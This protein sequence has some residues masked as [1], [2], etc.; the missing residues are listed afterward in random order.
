MSKTNMKGII[1]ST[2]A[3]SM[4]IKDTL[5]EETLEQLFLYLMLIN[6]IFHILTRYLSLYLCYSEHLRC[7]P[8]G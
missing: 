5:A 3:S 1:W 6:I 8:S 7:L 2:G 4:E